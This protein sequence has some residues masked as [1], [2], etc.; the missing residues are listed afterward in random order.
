LVPPP[1]FKALVAIFPILIM[2]TQIQYFQFSTLGSFTSKATSPPNSPPHA[3]L[4]AR[5]PKSKTLASELCF[6]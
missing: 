4:H 3:Q 6:V 5:A 2:P 1:P